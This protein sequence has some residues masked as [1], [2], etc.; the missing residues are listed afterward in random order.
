MARMIP[1]SFPADVA[2]GAEHRVYEALEDIDGSYTALY[3]V[4]WLGRGE[5]EGTQGQCDFLVLH[6]SSGA[7]VVE[8]KGGTPRRGS[9][10]QWWSSGAKSEFAIEDPFAQANR[11]KFALR[12]YVR[13]C[14][15]RAA[16]NSLWGHAVW[17]PDASAPADC[18]PVGDSG[19]SA[20]PL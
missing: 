11:S 9:D 18:G 1:E 5:H 12:D 20:K 2:S 4:A 8:V 13:S 6:P 15:N 16:A 14:G 3:D 10:G 7:L 19:F 17:F